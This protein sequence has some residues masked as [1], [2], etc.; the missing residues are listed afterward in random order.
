MHFR[1]RCATIPQPSSREV[2]QGREVSELEIMI[3]KL[4]TSEELD[5]P[6]WKRRSLSELTKAINQVQGRTEKI[7]QAQEEVVSVGEVACELQ[8]RMKAAIKDLADVVRRVGAQACQL[9]LRQCNLVRLIEKMSQDFHEEQE[10]AQA[11]KTTTLRLF[12]QLEEQLGHLE[13]RHRR[14]GIELV[15][16]EERLEQ[17]IRDRANMQA[18]F[19]VLETRVEKERKDL[20]TLLKFSSDKMAGADGKLDSLTLWVTDE[21]GEAADARHGN[22]KRLTH[23]EIICEALS[24]SKFGEKK[25]RVWYGL[26]LIHI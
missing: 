9:E 5:L 12:V 10:R 11:S 7:I 15:E 2:G 13:E 1:R 17:E 24:F 6:I 3:W 25:Q 8:V 19:D 14:Q 4:A 22:K 20:E 16:T 21:V 23:L 18:E 26:S